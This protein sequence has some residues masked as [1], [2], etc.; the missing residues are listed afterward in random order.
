[1]KKNFRTLIEVSARHIHLSQKDLF[2]LFGKN[3]KLTLLRKISQPGQYAAKETV[4]VAG[5]GGVFPKVRVVGPGRLKTQL[6]I[7]RTDAY[8]LEL[9]PLMRRSGDL[10]GTS[11]GVKVIG[12]RGSIKMTSGVIIAQRHLHLEPKLAKKYGLKHHQLVSV[13]IKGQRSLIFHRVVVRSHPGIDRL[14]FQI[15]TD[16][17]NAAGVK[18]RAYGTV[19][20]KGGEK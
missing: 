14:S 19:L 1:M 2:R 12:P 9:N 20:L 7:S 4:K 16:E 10:T 11:G 3:Y 18:G 13:K 6:E 17:A 8:F 15:D 5:P